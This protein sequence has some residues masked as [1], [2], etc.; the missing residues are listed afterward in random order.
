MVCFSG[1][2]FPHTSEVNLQQVPGGCG[3]EGRGVFLV[4]GW[5]C[6]PGGRGVAG[7]DFEGVMWAGGRGQ[8]GVQGG[9]SGPVLW[10]SVKPLRQGG[11]LAC[12][13]WRGA[14]IK[15]GVCLSALGRRGVASVGCS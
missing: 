7:A 4:G 9:G 11:G 8:S 10:W 3:R 1:D 15:C 2:P 12:A 5:G 6:G 14:A 13:K